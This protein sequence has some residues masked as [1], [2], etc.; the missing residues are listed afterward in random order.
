MHIFLERLPCGFAAV[1]QVAAS[2]IMVYSRRDEACAH[3]CS[4]L[5]GV[6]RQAQP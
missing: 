1:L 3:I 2:W 5:T 6:P 4:W